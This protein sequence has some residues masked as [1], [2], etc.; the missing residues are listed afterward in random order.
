VA[1][2]CFESL[3]TRPDWVV[4]FGEGGCD[5][6][7][8]TAATNL[9]DTSAPDNDGVTRTNHPIDPSLSARIGLTLP[10]DR[11]YC[12]RPSS[13][14]PVVPSISP[15]SYVCNNTAFL[16]AHYFQAKEV[17]YGFIHLPPEDCGGKLKNGDVKLMAKL[18]KALIAPATDPVA[19]PWPTDLPSTQQ[20]L[21]RLQ[22]EQPP[23][24]DL[25]FVEKLEALYS[26]GLPT[27]PG[28]AISFSQ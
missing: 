22:T 25:E 15:G 7:L 20:I 11:A 6:R 1:Q 24:C 13:R 16:L 12:E 3:P 5:I 26:P 19:L 27:H 17:P 21:S 2:A 14:F 4:S 18:L 8:E 9:D 23:K 10:V 28:H